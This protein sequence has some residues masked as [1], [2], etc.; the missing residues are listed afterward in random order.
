M[1]RER[2]RAGLDAARKAGRVGSRRHKLTLAKRQ[3]A[4]TMVLSG[5]KTG[6]DVA[7]L[8]QV[9]PSTISRLLDENRERKG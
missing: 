2:T 4:L 1:L 7:R 8:F 6:A 5:Q 3:E 9:H